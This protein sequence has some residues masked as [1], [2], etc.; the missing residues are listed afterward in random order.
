MGHFGTGEFGAKPLEEGGCGERGGREE[1]DL[2][3]EN[4]AE[5]GMRD[6]IDLGMEDVGML[7]ENALH[8]VGIDILTCT[9]HHV[10]G[11]RTEEIETFGV[12]SHEVACALIVVF[13]SKHS[14]TRFHPQ[15]AVTFGSEIAK[16]TLGTRNGTANG[17]LIKAVEI[18]WSS[19]HEETCLGCAIEIIYDRT[20]M[21]MNLADKR[22][23][24]A[25]AT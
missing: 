16:L 17:S 22:L 4:V 3:M 2:G 11:S 10:V 23:V 19:K 6:C 7:E 15:S 14:P 12:A 13:P 20:Q 18:V 24:E 5:V 25:V 8:I 1:L 9:D 21:M